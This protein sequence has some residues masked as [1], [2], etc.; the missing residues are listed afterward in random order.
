MLITYEDLHKNTSNAFSTVLNFIG[1]TEID[2][3]IL[4]KSIKFCNF[5]N[6]KKAEE[7]DLFN[8][9]RLRAKSLKD[10][11]SFKV[12]KGKIGGYVDYLSKNDIEYIDEIINENNHTF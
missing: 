8:S 7:K 4:E 1:E 9:F 3:N 12:R 5:E 10:T 6:L 11:E 2:D